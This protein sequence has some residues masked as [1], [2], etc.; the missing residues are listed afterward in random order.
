MLVRERMTRHLI[1]VTPDLTVDQAL[2]LI[3]QHQVLRLPV[4]DASRHLVGIVAEKDLL[5]A[6]PSPASGF[7][8][9]ETSSL[10]AKTSVR[11]SGPGRGDRPGDQ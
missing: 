10:L 9:L 1:T 5:C 8:V 4:P 6:S 3:R 7:R 11:R 2:R